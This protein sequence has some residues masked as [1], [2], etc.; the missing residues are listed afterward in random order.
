M[1]EQPKITTTERLF[2]DQKHHVS[3]W[4]SKSSFFFLVVRNEITVFFSSAKCSPE[5][6]EHFSL[7]W[8]GSKRNSELFCFLW[9][10]SEQFRAFLFRQTV[11]FPL[12]LIKISVGFMFCGI[13]FPSENGNPNMFR[14]I[15][16]L[17]FKTYKYKFSTEYKSVFD[18]FLWWLWNYR[19]LSI[20]VEIKLI[21]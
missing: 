16:G 7:L 2:I 20:H 9:N 17:N 18:I 4:V 6:S 21:G 12:A 3:E 13:I 15:A 19:N 5:N 8:N 11:G 14:N 1:T 10:G